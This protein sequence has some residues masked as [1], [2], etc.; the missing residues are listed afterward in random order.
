[1]SA[2]EQ[3]PLFDPSSV[4]ER[5]LN[6]LEH[7]DPAVL[8]SHIVGVAVGNFLCALARTPP[9]QHDIADV[10]QRIAALHS[11]I[12]QPPISLSHCNDSDSQLPNAL[13]QQLCRVELLCSRAT[14]LLYCFPL[15]LELIDRLL[16]D[17][18]T[19]VKGQEEREAVL[20]VFA[21]ADRERAAGGG[22]GGGGRPTV[23]VNDGRRL[24]KADRRCYTLFAPSP[25]LPQVGDRLH[26]QIRE[27]R[28]SLTQ[29][30]SYA[31]PTST[32]ST[33][34]T[35]PR[36]SPS[37]TSTRPLHLPRFRH[38]KGG[39][40]F[41]RRPHNAGAH[42][43]QSLEERSSAEVKGTDTDREED[44]VEEEEEEPTFR[45]STAWQTHWPVE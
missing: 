11:V 22:G 20:S 13:L 17:G 38:M 9:A 6:D 25:S 24:P 26:A 30:S 36:P 23:S 34:S 39:G 14:S 43:H 3:A 27:D 18:R 37:V 1:M 21:V 7:I 15:S 8:L 29:S 2:F 41:R 42:S 45:L 12:P 16:V 32:A 19:Q 10:R 4:G 28:D 44:E 40:H 31:A 33:A 35:G 5:V